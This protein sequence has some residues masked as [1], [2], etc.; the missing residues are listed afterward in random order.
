[1][2]R[3][4]V[5]FGEMMIRLSPPGYQLI[6]DSASFQVDV[7]GS[8]SNVAVAL[9]GFNASVQYVTR[10]PKNDLSDLA[11]SFLKKYGVNTDEILYG[12]DRMG[13]YF[14]ENGVSV[15]GGKVLYDR[16]FSG[17][18]SLAPGMIDWRKIFENAEWFHWSGITPA[19]SASAADATLE[20][21]Q[22]AK[23]MGV[24]VSVDLNF[25]SNL[26]KYGK[27]PS[28]VM[29]ELVKYC[30]SITASVEDASVFFSISPDSEY[31]S[32]LRKA[33]PNLKKIASSKR[34][35]INASHNKWAGE[36]DIEGEVFTSCEYDI[37]PIVDRVGAGDS[38]MAGLIYGQLIF[39][40]K[41]QKIIDFATATAALKH[42]IPG[43]ISSFKVEEIEAF[44][45]SEGKGKISR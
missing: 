1:M 43:D 34:I 42:T 13:I 29:P 6:R 9:A 4:I 10:L 32:N 40:E 26:W 24:P 14:L 25:R 3:N 7:A 20:A 11:I 33:F 30:Q 41:P 23:E 28:E 35:S 12:G 15:R 39:S 38:F 22:I 17:M 45:Q 27:K 5:T 16:A 37:Y 8:E 36:L 18:V 31:K 21:L 19:I 2:K 44:I